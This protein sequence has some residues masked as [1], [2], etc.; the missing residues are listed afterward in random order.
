[1][2]RKKKK[3]PQLYIITISDGN[4][5]DLNKTMMSIDNQS[6]KNYKNLIITS[7]KIKKVDKKFKKKNR[8]FFYQK[9]SSI[10]EA[11]NYGLKK[12]KNR[13]II[14]LNS[15]DIFFSKLSLNRILFYTKNLKIKSCLMLVTVLKNKKDYFFPKKKLFFSKNFLTHSSFIRPPSNRKINF[16]VKNK[17]NAD[18]PWMK[19]NIN[20]FSIKK[21]YI[22]LTIFYLGGISNFPSKKSIMIKANNDNISYLK[23]LIKFFLL[24][25][26]G[27]NN[28]YKIIYYFKY[29]RVNYNNI[30]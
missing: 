8:Y 9:K 4:I 24:K 21:I 7:N 25:L 6:Y 20:K 22:P 10:Y 2:E 30:K 13:F 28:Y 29:D 15:G 18:G 14:F 1:M 17:I 5:D 3:L 16:D 23:E 26:V 11:M 27:I 12:S 19:S